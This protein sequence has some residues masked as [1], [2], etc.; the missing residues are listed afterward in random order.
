MTNGSQ[1]I[2]TAAGIAAWGNVRAKRDHG[3][4]ANESPDTR[5][6]RLRKHAD[7]QRVYKGSR[8][9]FSPSMSF[10]SSVFATMTLLSVHQRALA[11]V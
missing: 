4:M 11:W 9:H 8:K 6:A 1:A 3:S 10:I 2:R 5:A 7:Y